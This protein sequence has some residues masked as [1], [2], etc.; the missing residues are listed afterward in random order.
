MGL[1]LYEIAQEYEAF[2]AAVDAGEIPEEAIA[3]TLEAIVSTLEDKAD[4]VA[5][6]IKNFTAEIEAIKAE[7]T[8]LQERRK[9]KERQAEGLKSYLSETLLR[10]GFNKIE[11]ARN[12]ISFR[13]SESVAVENEEYFIEWAGNH[14]NQYLTYAAPKINRAEIKKALA[15]GAEIEGVHIETKQNIQIK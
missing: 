12:K 2:L 1:K 10:A 14:G 8:R 6:V 5:C 11:S 7:E 4:N 3:D 15:G 9:Q 13:K